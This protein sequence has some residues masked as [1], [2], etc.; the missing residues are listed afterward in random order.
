MNVATNPN[1]QP[2]PWTWDL[3]SIGGAADAALQEEEG[4][5]LV[6]EYGNKLQ[7]EFGN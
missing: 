5:T 2:S 4:N 6:D 1:A 7:E 3:H